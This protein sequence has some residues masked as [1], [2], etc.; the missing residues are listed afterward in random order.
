[1]SEELSNEEE[2]E[3]FEY[4]LEVGALEIDG[5]ASDGEIMFKINSEKMKEYCPDMLEIMR[6]DLESSLLGLYE[7]GLVEMQYNENLEAIFNISPEGEEALLKMGFYNL[8]G[9]EEK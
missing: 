9:L 4:L 5:V 2:N 8:D 3:L 6:E 1:M 7:Q